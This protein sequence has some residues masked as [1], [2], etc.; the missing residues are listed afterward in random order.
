MDLTPGDGM[1]DCMRRITPGLL[2]LLTAS[3][4]VACS[5]PPDAETVADS[6]PE[7]VVES[8]GCPSDQEVESYLADWRAARPTMPLAVGGTIE[9][10]YCSQRKI[11]ERLIPSL[12][13][14]VGYKAGITSAAAQETFGVSEPVR[15][16]LL[17]GML[18]ESG[19]EVSATSGARP[20][21]E[22]DMI[23]VVADEAINQ[24]TTPEEVLAH[25]SAI[26]PFIEMPDLSV[27][28]GQPLDGTVM[29]AINVAS[30]SGVVGDPVPVQR[31][32]EF[33]QALAEMTVRLVD[34]NG[35]VL[36]SAPGSAILGHPLNSVLWLLRS[37]VSV[38][39]GDYLSLGSF[40]TLLVPQAGQTITV[41]YEGL[42][43]DPTA[44]VTFR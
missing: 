28:E 44:S 15:G 11:I 18:L 13:S 14:P 42:P 25:I 35:E 20:R 37:G 3:V 17:E 7:P 1:I 8:A 38:E 4:V 9:D 24:A 43:G 39:A 36:M 31:T 10:A 34:Q 22:A 29:T 32:P 33:L 23:L 26:I 30:R 19:A 21:F 40:G 41:S 16:V 2:P 5:S 27:A 12:G 6:A